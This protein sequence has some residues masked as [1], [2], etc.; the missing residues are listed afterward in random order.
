MEQLAKVLGR[1]LGD[2]IDVSWNRSD[3]LVDPGRRFAGR[4]RE[5]VAEGARRAGEDEG[6]DARP[7]SLLEQDQRPHDIRL[8]ERLARMGRDMRFVQRRRVEDH[9]NA[10]HGARDRGAVGDRADRVGERS[11]NDVEADRV[12]SGVA[13]SA[14]Q[15]F[16][17]MPG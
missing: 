2:A 4:G 6:S 9:I 15:R 8:D 1:A 5:G 16:A 13:Q 14:H 3:A 12:A 10:L 11:G 17:Q 7:D